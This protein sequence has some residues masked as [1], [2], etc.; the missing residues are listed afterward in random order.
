MRPIQRRR[1]PCETLVWLFGQT[2]YLRKKPKEERI[3]EAQKLWKSCR[4]ERNTRKSK[5][6]QVVEQ[7]LWDMTTRQLGLCMYCEHNTVHQIEHFWPK[8]KYPE[9]T[10]SWENLLFVCGECNNLKSTHFQPCSTKCYDSLDSQI[11][12]VTSTSPAAS[13]RS[14]NTRA[15]FAHGWTISPR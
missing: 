10:F 7:V 12:S 8:E 3:R 11:P 6:M 2:K 5:H 4:D 13:K 15:S 1:L 14:R 9:R